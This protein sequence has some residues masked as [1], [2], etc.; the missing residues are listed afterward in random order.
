MRKL[1]KRLAVTFIISTVLIAALFIIS[2]FERGKKENYHYLS[3]L[4]MGVETNLQSVWQ[5]YE[6][7]LKILED[8]YLNRAWAVEYILANSPQKITAEELEIVKDLMEVQGISVTD[9]NGEICLAVGEQTCPE[10]KG[11]LEGAETRVVIE[12][13]GFYDRPSY[14]FVEVKGNSSE[15]ASV[16]LD[17]R[18]GRLGLASRKELIEGTLKQATTEEDTMLAAIGQ[19][20]GEIV[21]ITKNNAQRLKI[22]G[23]NT[24]DELLELL[25]NAEED[26]LMILKVNGEHHTAVV[27]KQEGM[28]FLAI[29]RMEGVFGNMAR[30]IAEGVAGIGIVNLLTVLLVHFHLKKYL[31]GQIGEMKMEIQRVL[32]EEYLAMPEPDKE[33]RIPEL[34]PL[35]EII[36]RLG[37]GYIDK[38]K[39]IT[40]MKSQL[41]LART[42]AHYDQLTGLYNRSGFVNRMEKFLEKDEKA[43]IL[44]LFDL[45]NF[46]QV[47]DSEGHPEGDRILVRFAECLNESFR[48]S[49]YI[50]RLGGDEFIVLITNYISPKILEAKFQ[51]LLENVRNALGSYYEKYQVSVSIGAVPVDGDIKSYDGLYR[52]AD[53]ALYIAKY[54]GKDQYYINE[55]KI[56]CMKR[57]CTGCRRD[58]PRSKILEGNR[59]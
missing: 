18:V 42:E 20:K 31:F 45:D 12:E 11:G 30:T 49:D 35:A 13:T 32:E 44:I 4:L 17:A 48:K 36:H 50:G 58:C 40:H 57:K 26:K 9:R 6:E 38:S 33:K 34:R 55:R 59:K 3:Q 54:L 1:Y 22:E 41:S 2:L 52:C 15:Y 25:E 51:T 46:K 56:S 16:R 24:A 8:D 14:F 10:E 19:E 29:T 5:D 23:V 28:Y 37:Q 43:G 21:G 7:K 39:G 27:K 53:T 47:N